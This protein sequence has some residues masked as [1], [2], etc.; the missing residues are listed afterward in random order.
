MIYN[1]L[2]KKLLFIDGAMGTMLGKC[3]C[4]PE[5]L[6]IKDSE[7]IKDIHLS[8]LEAGADIITTNTFGAN[9]LKL[10]GSGYSV[11]EIVESGV[12]NARECADKYGAFV[13][14]DIGPSG[15]LLSPMGD[16]PFEKAYALFSE[17]VIAGKGAD[18]IS[19][20][21]MTD[22]Y[23]LK[24]AVLAAKEN[25]DLP[26]I[27]QVSCDKSGKLLCGADLLAVIAMLEGLRV[28]AIGLNCGFGPKEFIPLFETLKKY[29]SIP[30]ALLPNAGMPKV[31]G[32]KTIYDFTP[33]QFSD[34][35]LSF[36][37]EG[38]LLLGGCCG[39]TPEHIR[40]TKEKCKDI[41]AVPVTEKNY[42]V[43]SSYGNAVL[44]ENEPVIIG[45]RIN[46]TGKKKL[47][48]ALIN[49]DINYILKEGIAQCEAGAKILD[50]NVGLP[51]IDEVKMLSKAVYKL[52]EIL[53]TPLQ[54]DS[55]NEK[56][57]AA[58]MR[59]YNGKP[60][61][62]SV[63]GK[64]SSM[65]AIFP[66]VAKYGGVLVALT[67]DERGVAESCE[68]KIEIAKKLISE[69]AK[70]GIAKKDIVIDPLTLTVSSNPYAA[71]ETL[72]AVKIL[73]EEMGVNTVL[74]VS[75]ISFGLPE[76]INVNTA[77]LTMA[78]QAGLKFAIMNPLSQP[79]LNAF[80]AYNVLFANDKDCK[81]YISL[82]AGKEKGD[83]PMPQKTQFTLSELIVLGFKD[84]TKSAC[85]SLLAQMKPL[86]IINTQIIP[87]LDE[88]GAD[89][90]SGKI[91]LPN[92]LSS[93]E[94][95]QN[96]FAA[97]KESSTSSAAKGEKIIL[98]TVYGDIHDI[99]KNIVKLLLE[100]YGFDVFDLGKDVPAEKIVEVA[101]KENVKLI[102]LSALMTTTVSAMEET[103]ALLRQ[104]GL[105]CRIMVG[106]AVL[107][108]NYAK[109][110]GADFYGKDALSAVNYAKSILN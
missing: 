17:M 57:L 81:N 47:K 32:N 41:K 95:A 7:R 70:Y 44:V 43:I 88:V 2:G 91:F 9:A 106:G 29:C 10:E 38:A 8:Y 87:A 37:K 14:L 30:V 63:N 77:F 6:N 23:E 48:E 92:L 74:G 21:T 53:P 108:E 35:M 50:V 20:E 84:E 40:L 66:L 31:V 33:E 16:L 85:A 94:A 4:L 102:G 98:A 97:I 56:A 83:A 49:D 54:L 55:S 93:A 72:K 25:S 58:A 46:P 110:I 45:E 13:T 101:K 105:D 67:L 42:T 73:T 90:E 26:V 65:D 36:A 76:R 12:K 104:S 59:I 5:I 86:D 103:I 62:N 109:E 39:T 96:A 107:T 78:L 61:I 11:K 24:A 22:T 52:Q 68:E 71:I 64:Q 60:M 18:L 28:D 80:S 75:N 51:E 82:F 27:A 3:D 1:L 19:I 34:V 89:Y 69:A 99:G 100:N 15:K 79:M